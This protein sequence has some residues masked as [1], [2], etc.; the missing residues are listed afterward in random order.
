MEGRDAG[1][2]SSSNSRKNNDG[3]VRRDSGSSGTNASGKPK[4]TLKFKV[5]GAGGGGGAGGAGN[6]PS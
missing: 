3:L 1:G 4:L 5:G 6:P 2:G